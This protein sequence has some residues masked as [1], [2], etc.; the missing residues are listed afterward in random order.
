[1][2][3]PGTRWPTVSWTEGQHLAPM[4]TF[5]KNKASEWWR[6]MWSVSKCKFLQQIIILTFYFLKNASCGKWLQI[7]YALRL[8]SVWNRNRDP[9]NINILQFRRGQGEWEHHKT[10]Y[11][12]EESVSLELTLVIFLHV[13]KRKDMIMN[14]KYTVIMYTQ[15][16]NTICS[17]CDRFPSL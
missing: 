2:F 17:Q 10:D 13:K 12:G 8:K 3:R 14:I 5:I 9:G 11:D 15:I 7:V 6:Q 4:K 1:M 16:L